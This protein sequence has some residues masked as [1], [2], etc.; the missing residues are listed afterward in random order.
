M[1]KVLFY[2][3]TAFCLFLALTSGAEAVR[4]TQSSSFAFGALGAGGAVSSRAAWAVVVALVAGLAAAA[5]FLRM[6]AL[7][8]ARNLFGAFLA[9]FAVTGAVVSLAAVLF[10]QSRIAL[11]GAD[12][13]SLTTLRELHLAG[14][15][16]F[17]FF[18]ALGLLAMRPYFRIQASR[19][20]SI[21]VAFPLPLFALIIV[22]EL[23]IDPSTAPLPA[24]TPASVVFFA[25]V[26][27]LF[28]SIAVHC[29][30]HR[31]LFL[32]MTNL[33]ELLDSRI[34]PTGRRP[35]RLGGAA[36]DS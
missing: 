27:V 1:P 25:V 22:Q 11:M 19:L 33:R 18:V 34:D 7:L 12:A 23:F 30:R 35:I 10:L 28:F 29:V 6:A 8:A 21:S 24:A 31:H 15:F 20:L 26:A 36:F 3:G 17:G 16:V 4:Q 14:C 32:E 5:I 9:V 2:A 13:A